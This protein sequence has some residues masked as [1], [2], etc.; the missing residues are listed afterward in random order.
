MVQKKWVYLLTMFFWIPLFVIL[1][2]NTVNSFFR[3]GYFELD[4]YVEIV[5]WKWDNP[6]VMIVGTG[7][8]LLLLWFVVYHKSVDQ[9]RLLRVVLWIAGGIS[10]FSI[11]AFRSIAKCDSEFVSNAAIQFLE[12]NYEA[13]AQGQYLYMYPFQIGLTAL[14]ELI[15]RVFGV[16]N[17]IVFQ[18]LN[19]VCILSIVKVLSQITE[20]LFG[21]EV[22]R[23]EITLSAGLLPLFL[24]STFVYGDYIGLFFGV[25]GIAALI[26]FLKKERWQELLYASLWFAGGVTVKNN[27]NVLVIAAVIALI[28]YA[29][30]NRKYW[31]L[32]WAIGL[33]IVAQLGLEIVKGIYQ[34]RMGEPI[35]HGIPKIAWIAMSMQETIEDGSASGWYNGYNWNVYAVHDYDVEMTV[36]ACKASLLERLQY[37]ISNPKAAVWFFFDKFSSQWNEPTFMSI[38]TNEWYSRNCE[39]QSSLAVS[40][41][42]YGGRSIL[43]EVMNVYHFLIMLGA[44]IGLWLQRKDWKLEK[45][46]FFLNIFGGILFHMLWE[47]KARYVLCYFVLMLPIA[48]SGYCSLMNRGLVWLNG[49]KS[50]K[51][52]GA[53]AG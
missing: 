36:A 46:Y 19:L 44:A 48:A 7:V 10:L 35:P 51:E 37:F 33:P 4:Q 24:L 47:A 11:L 9:K 13:F 38:Q 28:L 43:T 42:Y 1:A 29:V 3:S 20:E 23:I 6:V 12:N 22:C 8:W 50:K 32:V 45:A 21:E 41:L 17:Y 30:M 53:S 18:L 52:S 27:I 16:Q 14:L 2:L 15:Y 49:Q 40:L 34:W 25:H 5:K 39:P 31:V 26:C